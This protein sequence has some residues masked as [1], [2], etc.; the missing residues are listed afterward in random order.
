MLLDAPAGERLDRVVARALPA[1]SRRQIHA[2]FDDGLVI[3]VE[4]ERRRRA[5]RG[6]R[7]AGVRLEV[8]AAHA[9]DAALPDPDME[10]AIAYESARWVIVDKPAG[11]ASTPVDAGELG[12]IANAL[13][14]R[15]PE[16]RGVGFRARE[17]GLCHRLDTDTSGLLLAARDAAAFEGARVAL[18]DGRIDKRYLLIC[19]DAEGLGDRGQIDLALRSRG[20]RVVVDPSGRPAST[21][22]RVRARSGKRASIEATAAGAFRH[23]L[24][25]HFAAIGA[26]LVGDEL[27]GGE[28]WPGAPPRHALHASH[29]ALTGDASLPGFAATSPLPSDLAALIEG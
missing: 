18:R 13:V 19:R 29:L 12:T 7:S 26:P 14:A 5:R 9:S 15:Y 23:Q 2:L 6:E 21:A 22:Y 8:A 27:Y 17:P 25:V 3:V 28:P 1:L 10:L 11:T 4:G 16:M 24:R 20:D